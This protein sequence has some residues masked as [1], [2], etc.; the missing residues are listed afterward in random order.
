MQA[1][2]DSTASMTKRLIKILDAK[3]NKMDV[4]KIVEGTRWH[5]SE[6]KNEMLLILLKSHKQLFNVTLVNWK[7]KPVNFELKEGAT[8]FHGCPFPVPKYII[9]L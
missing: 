6:T 9:K 4:P 7:T 3:Y 5:L 1:D 2:P 8:P